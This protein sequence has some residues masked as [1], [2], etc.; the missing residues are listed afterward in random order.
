MRVLGGVLGSGLLAVVLSS[1]GGGNAASQLA[2]PPDFDPKGQT[3]CS[4][5]KS[6]S[7]PLIVEWPSADRGA[8]EAQA[9]NHGVVVVRYQGCEMQVLDGCT[10]P[11]K[12]DYS[13]ITRKKDRVVIRDTDDLYANIPVGA[14]RFEA[15]LEKSGELD[16]EMTLVGRWVAQTRV[17]SA[18][19]LAGD[20]AGATHVIAALT[21]GSFTF[22]SGADATV[23]GGAA[24][25]GAGG[26][27][28]SSATREQLAADGNASACENAGTEDK[29]PPAECNATIRIEVVPVASAAQAATAVAESKARDAFGR[30]NAFLADVDPLI[31]KLHD[32]LACLQNA[33]N[34]G[35]RDPAASSRW[36]AA[37]EHWAAEHHQIDQYRQQFEAFRAELATNAGIDTDAGPQGRVHWLDLGGRLADLVDQL[38]RSDQRVKTMLTWSDDMH[39][40]YPQCEGLLK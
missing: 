29:A 2:K 7:K 18:D 8:L 32:A 5:E 15:Q 3:K 11:V 16:V 10:V 40:N 30:A 1:C 33:A 13:P 22:S 17:V 6:Q 39:R 23:G 12:Y 36:Q 20:C 34:D 38:Q 9:H 35:A 21:V 37:M 28:K 26:G 24:V 25:L 31:P 14:A 19:E 27:A 4:V